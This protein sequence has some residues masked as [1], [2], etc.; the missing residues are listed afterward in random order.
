MGFQG[1][2][3]PHEHEG[4]GPRAHPHSLHL[5][6]GTAQLVVV[7]IVPVFKNILSSVYT[8]PP[9]PGMGYPQYDLAYPQQSDYTGNQA[10]GPA[11]PASRNLLACSLRRAG[12]CY[13]LVFLHP[14]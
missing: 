12:G 13:S 10:P 7:C 3:K 14:F 5:W 2:W 9:P 1:P 6:L 8:H 4:R 11:G